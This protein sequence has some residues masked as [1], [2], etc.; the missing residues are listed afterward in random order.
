MEKL[1]AKAYITHNSGCVKA[2]VNIC[3]D[4][5][6]VIK[7]LRLI[8]HPDG[9]IDVQMPQ[10]KAA[11]G[12]YYPKMIILSH[13][14]IFCAIKDKCISAYERTLKYGIA[15]TSE[16]YNPEENCGNIRFKA[17]IRRIDIPNQS[18]KAIADINVN[19]ELMIKD[20]CVYADKNGEYELLFPQ[21]TLPG[22]R[23][24]DRIFPVDETVYAQIKKSISNIYC[25]DVSKETISS[26]SD[27]LYIFP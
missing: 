3:Y 17:N 2:I 22:G 18:V 16:L 12:N 24:T 26:R 14:G 19:N 5:A 7:D 8:E 20:I 9:S 27:A 21:K 15:D 6:L 1:T 11:D 23:K 25:Q 13:S 4:N 10:S